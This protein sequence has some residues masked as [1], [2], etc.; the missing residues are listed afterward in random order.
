MPR[1]P[2]RLLTGSRRSQWFAALLLLY[3]GFAAYCA[4]AAPLILNEYNGVASTR[5]LNGGTAA[6]DEQGGQ[7][8]DTYFGRIVGNGGDWFELVVTAQ[9]LDIR[10]WQIAIDDNHGTTVVTVTFS[11][12]ALLS[13]LK[14]GTIITIAEDQPEDASYDP[15]AGDWWLQLRAGAVGSGTYVSATAFDVSNDDTVFDIR[16]AVG[17]PVFGPVG[18][19]A[20]APTGI[21]NREMAKLETNPSALVTASS[22]DYHDGT[23][24]TYGSPNAWS[25]GTEIQDF[26][27]LRSGLPVGDLDFDGIAD[28]ADNCPEAANTAQT[29]VDS[30]AF[31]DACDPDQGSPPGPGLPPEGCAVVDPFDP[32]LVMDVEIFMT[33]ADWDALRMEPRELQDLFPAVCPKA[34]AVSPFDFFHANV[35]VN[36]V[37]V[38]DVAVRKKGFFGSIDS[39]RP[40]FR[41]KVDEFNDNQ[42]VFGLEDITLNNGNQ[43]PSRIKTCL[44]YE[45]FRAAGVKAP[46]CNFAH[47]RVTHEGGTADLGIYA[48]V[49]SIKS[50][51]LQRAFGSASGNLYEAPAASD[52]RPG[53]VEF[54]EIKNNEESNDTSDIW[55][56][57]HDLF[58]VPRADLLAAI[59]QYVDVDTFLT[60]WTTEALVGHW[61]GYASDRNNHYLYVNPADGLF[62]F[63]PWGTD[64]T[65]GRGNPFQGE[66]NVAPLLWTSGYLVRELYARPGVP[67]SYQ[68]RMQLLFDTVWSEAALLA[69]I[70]RMEAL[71]TPFAGDISAHTEAIRTF[72]STRRAK[73]ANDF[74]GGPPVKPVTALTDRVCFDGPSFTD[75]V[76]CPDCSFTD[77]KRAC[78]EAIAKAGLDLIKRRMQMVQRCRDGLNE[79]RP[80]VF[81]DG[82]T[83]VTDPQDCGDEQGV[84]EGTAKAVAKA[85]ALLTRRCKAPLVASLP[86][87]GDSVD[88]LISADGQTGCLRDSQLEAADDMT[89]A[90]YGA[91]ATNAKALRCQKGI[92]RAGLAYATKALKAEQTCRNRV[93]GYRTDL[94]VDENGTRGLAS[95]AD[96]ANEW[97]TSTAIARFGQKARA[98][99]A[100]RG[101]DAPTLAALQM[102]ATTVDGLIDTSGTAGCLITTHDSGRLQAVR[103]QYCDLLICP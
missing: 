16:D 95:S 5:F 45:V 88:E 39:T 100:S 57:A 40:S 89:S 70:D 68:Q 23:S 42:R 73:F 56:F 91:P 63:I 49:E 62:R 18:E 66:G 9:T 24:S 85:R 13:A 55:R 17:A 21:N 51:F 14:A 27:A 83:P 37:A 20:G 69:E 19:G 3:V 90:A 86:T 54:Y 98:K 81:A 15:L 76:R 79:G 50:A 61:D 10:G 53:L 43:D 2:S 93:N 4:E 22:P 28:C 46:R 12:N 64:D 67:E 92:A 58:R 26:T 78:Q 97:E 72:I 59:G 31:G 33:Q 29:N 80:L 103:K 44:S 71:I 74:A 8:A 52:L 99:I 94:F 102:C 75:I 47:V 36:G 38:S 48:H 77:P 82:P 96:C 87:C 7:A 60:F 30:D 32:E 34:P 84:A 35:T 1:C 41:I 6:V 11:Q 101:C 65:F 25:G